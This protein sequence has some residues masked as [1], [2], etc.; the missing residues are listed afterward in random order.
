MAKGKSFNDFT[1]GVGLGINASSFKQVRDDLKLNLD[2]LSKMVKSYGKVLKIDPN[3]DLSKLFSEVQ[4]IQ[5]IVNGISKSDNSFAGFVDKGVLSR[6]AALETGLQSVTSISNEAAASIANLQASI[7]SATSDLK[8]AGQAKLSG[9]FGDLFGNLKDQSAQIK[10]TEKE[11]QNVTA[12]LQK[13]RQAASGIKGAYDKSLK[14]GIGID[15]VK[16][17]L[18][19]FSS[20]QG[21]LSK[22]KSLSFDQ[23]QEKVLQLSQLSMRL[24]AAQNTFSDSDFASAGLTKQINQFNNS[25]KFITQQIDSLISQVATRRNALQEELNHLRTMQADFNAKQGAQNASR[26][27]SLG[28]QTDIT[29]QVKTTP[30][31]NPGEWTTIINKAIGDITPNITPIKLTPTFTH[32]SKSIEKELCADSAQITHTLNVKFNINSEDKAAF[33]TK[34]KQI[35]DDIR[36]AKANIESNAKFKIGFTYDEEGRL[37]DV[38]NSV[39]GQL[40]NITVTAKLG[41]K[42]SF[43]ASVTNLRDSAKKELTN[44]P[45]SFAIGDSKT[46]IE[47]ASSLRT[48]IENKIGTIGINLQIQNAPQLMAQASTMTAGSIQPGETSGISSVAETAAKGMSDLANKTQDAQSK[49]EQIKATLKSLANQGFNS[50]DFIQLGM[51]DENLNHIKGSSKQLKEMTSR[52]A[53]LYAKVH[54]SQEQIAKTYGTG[55]AGYSAYQADVDMLEQMKNVLDSVLQ[56]QILYAQKKLELAEQAIAKETQVVEVKKEQAKI[57]STTSN[58]QQSNQQLAMSAEEATKKVRSLNGTLTQQKQVLKDLEANGIASKSLIRLGEWDKESGSFKKNAEDIRQLVN[59]YNELK[60]ARID[61]GGAGKP[62]AGEEASLRGKL[63]ALLREQKKHVSEIIAQNQQELTTV[64]QISEEYKQQNKQKQTSAKVKPI[65]TAEIDGITKK[66]EELT[67]KLNRA[68]EA[69]ELLSNGALSSITKTGLG[70]INKRLTDYNSLNDAMQQYQR[71]QSM[72]KDYD[73]LGL[74]KDERYQQLT[75][76]FTSVQQQ[77]QQIYKDQVA[78]ANNAIKRHEN[79]IVKEKELLEIK[80]KQTQ[81][82]SQQVLLQDKTTKTTEKVNKT[83]TKKTTTTSSGKQTVEKID[84]TPSTTGTTG[85]TPSTVQLD[86]ATL[87][88]LAQESTLKTIDGKI[89]NI[90][91]QLGQGLVI[92]G[93]NVA[94]SAQNVSVSGGSGGT[95][96]NNGTTNKKDALNKEVS[97]STISSYARQLIAFEEQVKRSGFYTDDLKNKIS[98]LYTQL[99]AVKTQDDFATY[100]FDLDRFK[101]G[102]EQVKTYSKL[103]QDF[104]KSQTKQIKLNDQISTSTGSTDALKEQLKVE[105]QISNDLDKQLKQYGSIYTNRARQ[106]AIDEAIK[107]ANQEISTTLAANSDVAINKQNQSLTKIVDNANTKLDEMQYKMQNS[108]VPMADAAI[109]KFKQYEQLLTTLKAKQQEIANN[110]SLMQNEDYKKNFES[111]LLQMQGVE[112]QFNTLAGSS[113]KFFTHIRSES[114]IKSLGANFDANNL[115]QLHLE[116]QNFANGTGVGAA[117]LVEFN[118]AQR[119]ATFEVN[120]GRGQVQQLKVAYDEATNSLGRYVAKTRTS[121]SASQQFFAG[122]KH[123]FQ[124]VAR[125]LTTFGSVYRLFSIIRKGVTDVKEIDNALTEL[126]KVTDATKESYNQFLKDMSK[127]AGV[128]GSTVKELTSSAA[129]WARLGYSMKEAGELASNTAILM[130]VSEFESVDKATDTLISAL[131]AYKKEGA[132]VGAFSM[133]II[134]QMNEVGNN[135]AISTSDLAESL[136]RSSAALVAANNSL[137][138]SIAMTAAANTT[139]QDPESVGNALKVVSMRIRG[140][141]TELEEAGEDTEGMVT[142]VS[143]LQEK[144]KA[145]T[146]IDGSGGI[147]IIANTG[148]FKSTY[149]VLLEISKVWEEMNDMS[150]AALLEVIAGKTRGSVVAALL[151]NGDVLKNAYDSASNSEGSAER[152]LDTYLDSVQGRLD[153]FTNE[154]QTFWMNIISSDTMK[155]IVDLGTNLLKLVNNIGLLPTALAGVLF[156]FTAIKK[157]N[158][159]T[160]FRD[161]SAQMHNYG[162]ATQNIAAIQSLNTG[163]G[164]VSAATFNAQNINAYAAAVSNLTAKQQASALASAGLTKAQIAEAMARNGVES[165]TIQQTIA[166]TN[167]ATAKTATTSATVAEAFAI[168]AEEKAKLSSV[169][170]DWLAANSSKQL[171]FALVQ[172]A[173]QRGVITPQIGAEIIAKY[174][175]VS[176]NNAAS[177]SVNGLTAS[178][179]AMMASN[180]IGWIIMLVGAVIALV[181]WI[182]TLEK[183]NE[184]LAQSANEVIDKYKQSTKTLNDNKKTIDEIADSYEKLSDGVDTLTNKNINLTTTSYEKYLDVCNKIANMYPELVTGFDEQGNAILSL[185][186]NVEQLIQAYKDAE[187]YSRQ[188]LISENDT[189]FSAFQSKMKNQY[190]FFGPV[191]VGYE[192]QLEFAKELKDALSSKDA[193]TIQSVYDHWFDDTDQDAVR[194]VFDEAGIDLS[195]MRNW[196]GIVKEENFESIRQKLVSFIQ[197]TTTEMN[198]ETKQITS[199]MDAYLGEDSDYVALD[200]KSKSYVNQIVSNLESEFISSFDSADALYNWIKT[201]IIDVFKNKSIVDVTNG[202]DELQLSFEKDDINYAD[203]KQARDIF[204]EDLQQNVDEETLVRIKIALGIDKTEDNNNILIEHIK[205]ILSS[206]IQDIDNSIGALSYTDLKIAGE[207]DVPEGTIMSWEQLL[208]KINEV[209][210]QYGYNVVSVKTYSALNEELEKYNELL[211]QTSEIISNDMEV[212]QEYKDSLIELGIS[213]QDLNECFYEGNELVVKNADRLNELL[214]ETKANTAQNAKLAKSQSMLD[215]YNLYKEMKETRLENKNLDKATVDYINS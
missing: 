38:V 173:V 107:N 85:T 147:D 158:P 198:N 23:L 178:I 160:I 172:E 201:N 130:N 32:S 68:K 84:T 121:V 11:L 155:D 75:S 36:T 20:L 210:K 123:S 134:N 175:L 161:L 56:S 206:D 90:L 111:L 212:T 67:V 114:D 92:N 144:I 176:A 57:E 16:Q 52:Y 139:I 91:Q 164:A 35:E 192:R 189:I 211:T 207:L 213:E 159:V 102:F 120:N 9:T 113:E 100:K 6:I 148:E 109:S 132:D 8:S 60:Q 116:M 118:D 33:D 151:Q 44:I 21:E 140:T 162:M 66:I 39:I 171:T 150:Q 22:S 169:A 79:A 87:S 83:T 42:K 153:L 104:V 190:P 115:A 174:N 41:N 93:D 43:L 14:S 194:K 209:K 149:E 63:A 122:I 180:P 50:E 105:E 7:N 182:S 177:M 62:A 76:K 94:I 191:E 133:E 137:E 97:M 187:Q 95:T 96:T 197:A 18:A 179:K 203:Y 108:K 19:E 129:D 86:A 4:K 77:L 45:V 131:Q 54:A 154:A 170:T 13:A 80:T 74:P 65:N 10:E 128:V 82:M 165:A 200:E 27:T 208:S 69:K 28:L 117:K 143:K 195:D 204:L 89:S 168:S 59:R 61:A 145:L 202:L 127:T 51:F 3:A 30:K 73:S 31:V 124:N 110:P 81:E 167:V 142:N 71:L 183:S 29:A 34:I 166:E 48:E 12:L 98:G 146:N 25:S 106:L 157:N 136:T 15:S 1:Y 47:S 88:S 103:Y 24:T 5:S 193:S 186:G 135:Y 214:N 49:V 119:T 205:K 156:Y 70:D 181:S 125:Y 78:Y 58:A 188:Q 26:G 64:K 17:W 37:R 40:K 53:E 163:V 141:K 184:E 46:I 2:N 152:E 72:I 215:Y 126:K 138:E 101:E 185:K 199:L 55:E 112:K 196:A 99:N